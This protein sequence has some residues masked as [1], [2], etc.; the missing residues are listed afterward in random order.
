MRFLIVGA[1]GFIGGHLLDY[2]RSIGY[3]AVG[4][5]NR[6]VA[7]GMLSFS[8]L[9]DRL[10]DA[11]PHSFFKTS[12]KVFVVV[13]AA[14]S[15]IDRC[16]LEQATSYEINVT[17]TILLLKDIR[18][19]GAVPVFISTSALYD[20]KLGYYNEEAPVSPICEY[21]RQ[22]AE[23]ERFI[24]ENIPE[25][26]V[27]RLDKIVGDEPSG[28]HLFMDWYNRI[29]KNEPIVCIDQLF[30]PTSVKDMAKAIVTGCRLRLSG[31]YNVAN[32]EFFTRVE[33]ARQFLAAMGASA[34][35]QLKPHEAF[36]FADPRLKRSY[37]DGSRF[38]R[39]TGMTFTSMRSLFN[40]FL[41]AMH[42]FK[43]TGHE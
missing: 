13:C 1:S 16:R 38:I 6:T 20:G 11:V 14:L 39:E 31:A 9:E 3:E 2:C 37:L 17:R 19:I 40:S 28:N 35:I 34:E 25:A 42:H 32:Q 41:V 8:L 4:T 29:R 27:L 24:Q 33:L 26:F 43:E 36:H 7:E 12:R 21:G 22:K 30:S 23:V 5:R 10:L 15:Q 18:S